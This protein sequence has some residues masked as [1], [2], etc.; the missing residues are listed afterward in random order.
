ML[1]L[2]FSQDNGFGYLA[3]GGDGSNAAETGNSSNFNEIESSNYHRAPLNE[4]DVDEEAQSITLSA[5][6]DDTNVNS[7]AGVTI[8]EIGIVD[9]PEDTGSSNQIFF[10]F[11]EIPQ[12][13]KSDNISLKYTIVV[14][15]L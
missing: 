2:A 5:V 7:S 6:F 3:L 12:I 13:L 4:E 14:S 8:N 1:R 15:M 10:A 9:Q 11:A